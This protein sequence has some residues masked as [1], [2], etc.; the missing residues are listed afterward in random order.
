MYSS[1]DLWMWLFFFV[2]IITVW[3]V[4]LFLLKGNKAHRVSVR[5]ALAWTL[6]W[7]VCAFIFNAVFWWYLSQ[8]QGMVIAN[9]KALEFFTG[10]VIEESLSFDNMFVILT[11]FHFFTVPQEYQRRVLLYGIS[12]AIVM[13]FIM[14]FS[15]VWIVTRFHWIL[16]VFGLF[17]IYTGI[18][19]I[20][21][22]EHERDLAQNPLLVWL[23][24][25]IRLTHHFENEKF[26]IRQN[27][28]W[29]ATPLF[30]VLVLIE[31]SDLIF[32]LDSIPAIFAITQDPFIIF[33][34]NIFAISGLRA[35]YFLLANMANRFYLLKYGI[36]LI[37]VFVGAKMLVE[38]WIKIPV[39]LTLAVIALLLATSMLLS[40]LR[41]K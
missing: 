10:Y 6:V 12:G 23:K 32:A 36:A 2:F 41:K 24:K 38:S 9:K 15:G 40:L 26:F 39:L 35:I 14:I 17:L 28:L 20:F 25:H 19:M 7:I 13:R 21:L 5:E 3:T 37:L 8:T 30:L 1:G 11:I 16:Y 33:T 18:K 34:S 22:V 31:I 4:D 29:Y 27:Y